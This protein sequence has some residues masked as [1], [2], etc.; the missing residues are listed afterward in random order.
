MAVPLA[1]IVN[2]LVTNVIKHVGPP[3]RIVIREDPRNTLTLSVSD[4]GQGPPDEQ[5]HVGMGSRI[6]R[7]FANQLGAEMET[8]HRPEGYTVVLSIPIPEKP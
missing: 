6:V 4:A 3:C 8:K 1:L 7:A 2:E 5:P